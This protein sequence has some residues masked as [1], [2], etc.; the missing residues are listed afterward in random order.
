[1]SLYTLGR[2]FQT[3]VR[4]ITG[5]NRVTLG[6]EYQEYTVDAQTLMD[7]FI[8]DGAV[9]LEGT[10]VDHCDGKV[11]VSDLTFYIKGKEVSPSMFDHITRFVHSTGGRIQKVNQ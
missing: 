7:A 10:S 2:C 11:R 9:V 4:Q 5:K 8:F 3:Y 1:M 6:I